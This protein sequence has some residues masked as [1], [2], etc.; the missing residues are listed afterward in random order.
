[1]HV[2]I[3]DIAQVFILNGGSKVKKTRR[4]MSL[5]LVCVLAIGM[6]LT[7]GCSKKDKA[8][9]SPVVVTVGDKE[10]QL[11]EMM[12]Y[13]YAVETT[14]ASYDAA[15][16][17]YYGTSY[18]DMEYS[19]G[20]TMREQTKKYVMDTAV[21]YEI[22]YEKALA[23][24]YTMTDE[25]KTE[26]E[27][28]AD[29]IMTNITEEQLK[30]TGFTKDVLT[31]VQEKLIVGEKYYNEL[32]E[33][34]DINEDEIKSGI[35]AEDYKQYDT[36][37]LFVP[38]QTYDANYQPVVLTDE[39]KE[40]ALTSIKNAL[41][42]VKAGE[43]FSAIAEADTTLQN[44][45]VNFVYGDTNA[46]TAY[47]DAAIK[48]DNDAVTND[49]VETSLGYYIIKMVNNNSTESY[50]AAVDEAIKAKQQEAFDADYENIKKEYTIT[51]NDAEWDKIVM[52]QTT[53][54]S[55]PAPTQAAT[56]VTP[57]PTVAE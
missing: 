52:G 5:L 11:N 29:Q 47:Q 43:E 12:Y 1:M 36:E 17:S 3:H 45:T 25:E 55:T 13:I 19:E 53:I 24:G 22:L 37:Y 49:I 32:A 31:K 51:V 16:Q 30:V 14:G 23:A 4:I 33:G 39:E 35:K 28:N 34:Y 10:I 7:T 48:L 42:K 6:T 38:T 46:E 2:K 21:M 20:V 50:D 15:Y 56:T 40:A 8:T 44:S 54:I 41:D 57:T 18:W 26:A 27:S 9:T